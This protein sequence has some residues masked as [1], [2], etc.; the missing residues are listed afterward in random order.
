VEDPALFRELLG[1]YR[2]KPA[3]KHD[4]LAMPLGG[5]ILHALAVDFVNQHA[6]FLA[7]YQKT[8]AEVVEVVR[9]ISVKFKEHIELHGGAMILYKDSNEPATR[10]YTPNTLLHGRGRVW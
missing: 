7:L 8:G 2:A 6:V 10:T 3:N 5:A 9:T 1:K 4:Y